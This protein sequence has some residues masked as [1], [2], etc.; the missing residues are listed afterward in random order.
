[1]RLIKKI[2]LRITA[3]FLFYFPFTQSL[4]AHLDSIP[5]S[6][7]NISLQQ[8]DLMAFRFDTL[9]DGFII[10][11]DSRLLEMLD[12]M[13]IAMV[14]RF[15]AL[16]TD[17]NELNIYGYQPNEIPDFPD[18]V[19]NTRIEALNAETPIELTYN[20]VVDN[21]I[22]LYSKNRRELTGRLLGLAE[23][24]FP[25]FEETLDKYDMP[26]EIKYLAVVESALNPRARSWVGA[27]GLW[28]FMY[29]TGKMYGLKVT[30]LVDDRNDP[31]K[32]TDAA[33]R[34]LR[35]LHDIYDDW[36]LALAA[37][38]SGAGNVNKAV[39]RAGGTKNYW[40]VWPY[41]PRE[42]RGYVPAF[43]AVNYVMHYHKEHNIYP[44]APDIVY[45]E[46]DTV[47]VNEALHLEQVSAVLDIPMDILQLLN[48][49]YRQ[50]IIPATEK[51]SYVL[52][53]PRAKM[54]GFLNNQDSISHY[55]TRSGIK[56]EKVLAEIK[57]AQER[58]VHIVKS[59]ENLGLI[60]RKYH[61][62][63]SSLKKWNNMRSTRIYPGQKLVVFPSP[64][65]WGK[66]YSKK[67][68]TKSKSGTH[69]VSNGESLSSI[70][71]KYGTSVDEL[72]NWNG[73]KSNMI[74]KGQSLVVKD[75]EAKIDP[76]KHKIISYEVQKGDTLWD[77]A[78]KYDGVS[79]DNLKAIN[80]MN[81]RSKLKPGQIIKIAIPQT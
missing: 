18:S 7:V 14:Y 61:V 26:L 59:G 55:K 70:A 40:A 76:S 77:I 56:R 5:D 52:R 38:N 33:C 6:T 64:G 51:K 28:Q 3:L 31:V 39:R 32:A 25:L 71:K 27:K 68:H 79:V 47:Y 69:I 17:T 16:K 49:A 50:D 45:Y 20:K 60:A 67:Q 36:S 74:R 80:N 73:L 10:K 34:H 62:S 37:Y 44:I 81:R 21:Y 43:I 41:L 72:K 63:V 1:M 13:S 58:Q 15:D 42:T 22:D 29:Y 57:K 4:F 66:S 78:K 11:K 75:P 54:S 19:L 35:D 30:S 2:T 9:P 8:S 23:L 53:L 46:T 65:Y 48:P 12:S 24:Y